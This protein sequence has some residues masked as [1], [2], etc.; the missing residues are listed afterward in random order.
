MALVSHQ[1][2]LGPSSKATGARQGTERKGPVSEPRSQHSP[3]HRGRLQTGLKGILQ[4][5]KESGDVSEQKSLTELLPHCLKPLLMPEPCFPMATLKSAPFVLAPS[6][7][8]KLFSF[9]AVYFSGWVW[10][11]FSLCFSKLNKPSV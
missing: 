8:K 5:G 9:T 1:N 2:Y 11:L 10:S 7:L 6:F 3:L 4:E